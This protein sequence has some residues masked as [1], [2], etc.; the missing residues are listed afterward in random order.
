MSIIQR[1]KEVIENFSFFEDWSDK[2]AYLISL[3]KSLDFPDDKKDAAHMVKGCQSQ[4]WFDATLEKGK[5]VFK[6]ISDAAI[7]SGLIGLLL[8][9]YSGATP[10]EILHS[11]TAF[12][13]EIGL[14]KHLSVT[15]NNG[16]HAM[17]NYIYSMARQYADISA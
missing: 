5:L 1:Q 6:G 16:L 17:V 13:D 14:S 3:G 8:T 15:R 4:V 9:V 12:M 11:D 2:Y 10:E 7:V